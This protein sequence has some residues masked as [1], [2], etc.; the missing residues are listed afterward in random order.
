MQTGKKGLNVA[1]N[2]IVKQYEWMWWKKEV[3]W[4]ING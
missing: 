2:E 1:T 3:K 4:W